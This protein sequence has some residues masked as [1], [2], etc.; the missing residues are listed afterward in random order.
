MSTDGDCDNRHGVKDAASAGAF[1]EVVDD[2][3]ILHRILHRMSSL[4]SKQWRK[5]SKPRV[6]V[7]ARDFVEH[8]IHICCKG[9]SEFELS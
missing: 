6:V 1:S 2:E 5:G 3:A 7:E 4:K 8:Y 9:L